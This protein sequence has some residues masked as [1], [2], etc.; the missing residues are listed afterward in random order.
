[1]GAVGACGVMTL[2]DYVGSLLESYLPTINTEGET[3]TM[4]SWRDGAS[5]YDKEQADERQ[6]KADERARQERKR[7]A[8]RAAD[9]EA[10]AK[11][12]RLMQDFLRAARSV[13]NPGAIQ[14]HI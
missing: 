2:G 4:P 5:R 12:D 3:F 11:A 7:A 13:G 1:M 8:E 9:L 6:R 14:R 10:T